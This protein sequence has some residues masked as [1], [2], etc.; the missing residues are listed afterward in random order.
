MTKYSKHVQSPVGTLKLVA[1]DRGLAA[2]LWQND[3]PKRVSIGASEERLDHPVLTKAERELDDYF[4]GRR[5][6]FDVD[7]D[8]NGTSFQKKVWA[9]LLEIPFGSTRT[10]AE[11]ATQLGKPSA[12]RAVGSANARNPISIIAPCHRV[13]GSNGDLTGYAGGLDAKRYLLKLEGALQA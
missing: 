9:A 10:Y 12:S 1:T 6:S 3:N 7:L 11:I 8:F 13:V 2:I 5:T 4:A